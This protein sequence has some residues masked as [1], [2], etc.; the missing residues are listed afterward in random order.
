METPGQVVEGAVEA[1][2]P[3][4]VAAAGG[5]G[6]GRRLSAA[7]RFVLT[8]KRNQ[9]CVVPRGQ[10]GAVSRGRPADPPPMT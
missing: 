2:L 6:A 8:M 4:L 5:Y 3:P 1:V 7:D 10:A 9:V